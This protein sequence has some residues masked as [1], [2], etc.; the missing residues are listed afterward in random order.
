VQCLKANYYNLLKKYYVRCDPDEGAT[1]NY[2][3]VDLLNAAAYFHGH[4]GP[5]L[6]LGLKA[7]DL[8]NRL[9]GREPFGTRVEIHSNPKPPQSC[10]VDGIQFSTGCTMGKGNISL[11]PGN[12]SVRAIFVNSKGALELKLQPWVLGEPKDH[13]R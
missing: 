7:G 2:G 8:S 4:N 1:V 12:G 9:L 5:F 6:V 10:M 3:P 13:E 11:H